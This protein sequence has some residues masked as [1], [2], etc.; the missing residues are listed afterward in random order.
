MLY[1]TWRYW[2]QFVH[3]IILLKLQYDMGRKGRNTS[4]AQLKTCTLGCFCSCF[5]SFFRKRNT[6]EN[7]QTLLQNQKLRDPEI[8]RR[9]TQW[10][11]DSSLCYGEQSE[12]SYRGDDSLQNILDVSDQ[13][14]CSDLAASRNPDQHL[15]TEVA[16]TLVNRK[17][18]NR[19]RWKGRLPVGQNQSDLISMLN[20]ADTSSKAVRTNLRVRRSPA[21]SWLNPTTPS[22][23]RSV[24]PVIWMRRS[25]VM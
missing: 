14:H 16:S 19:N 2:E 15:D 20:D 11:L 23:A 7:E 3:V 22:A 4:D 21:N 5:G 25:A 6:R 12:L 24:G 13:I 10:I 1:V 17:E 8:E 9:I 18:R